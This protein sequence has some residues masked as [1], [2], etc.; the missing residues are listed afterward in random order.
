MTIELWH[1]ACA[2]GIL[3]FAGLVAVTALLDIHDRHL[4]EHHGQ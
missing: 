4:R 2:M 1:L 3:A